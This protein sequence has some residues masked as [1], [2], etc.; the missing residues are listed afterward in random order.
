MWRYIRTS[1][2][3]QVFHNKMELFNRQA[4]GFRNFANYGMRFK[5][6]SP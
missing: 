6:L 2:I 5:V 4:Y 3:T 1:G